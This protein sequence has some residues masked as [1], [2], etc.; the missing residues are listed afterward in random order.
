MKTKK[1]LFP[2]FLFA[3]IFIIIYL[4]FAAKPLSKEYQFTPKWI[5]SS[6]SQPDSTNNNRNPNLF[7]KLGKK[8]GYFSDNGK[9]L[10]FQNYTD[11]AAISKNYYSFYNSNSQEIPFYFP[12]GEKA[13][14]INQSGYPYFIN[15]NIYI[16][17]PGGNSYGLC[18]EKGNIKWISEYAIPITAFSGNSNYTISGYANGAIRIHNNN[19]YKDMLEYFPGGSDY[20]VIY[21][22]DISKDGN[23]F[24]SV[25]GLNRQRF[26]LA[27]K[28]NNQAKIIYHE[29]LDSQINRRT[30]VKF[31]ANNSKI[32][33][34]IGNSVGIY[35]FEKEKA[36]F[37]D[38][39]KKIIS[40][41]EIDDMV[42]LLGKNNTDYTVYILGKKNILLGSFSF[43]AETACIQTNNN[44]LFLGKDNSI[45]KI[46]I[47][48]E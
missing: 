5:I 22:V 30:L 25:S 6:D 24:A 2:F 26:V 3:F 9:I 27:K 32:I 43:E 48:K 42:F 16:F 21:G 13:G 11:Y 14:T 44:S 35:D 37:I 4:I 17:L 7:F 36:S 20:P 39:D 41:E 1:T 29:F 8:L 15:E 23:Y 18:D 10:Q 45:S 28:E 47:T 38:V 12:N 46:E 40:I 19:D 34:D 31:V 33:F